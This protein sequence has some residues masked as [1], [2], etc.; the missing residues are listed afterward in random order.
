MA[1]YCQFM[2]RRSRNVRNRQEQ[3]IMRDTY[4]LVNDRAAHPHLPHSTL[5]RPKHHGRLR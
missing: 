3:W 2:R 1:I 5:L 4:S